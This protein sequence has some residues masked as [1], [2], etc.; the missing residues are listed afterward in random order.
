MAGDREVASP[1]FLRLA[2]HPLRW[3]L[4][5]ELSTGD[6][7]VRELVERTGEPQNLVSYHLRMLR[8]GGLVTARRSSRD[9]RDTYYHLDL[10]HCAAGLADVGAALHPWLRTAA[11]RPDAPGARGRAD[12]A[13]PRVLFVCTG[14]SARSPIAEAL[15]RRRA[16]D[17]VVAASAGVS[18]K[19]RIHP[20]AVRVLRERFDIDIR[21]QAPRSVAAVAAAGAP[22]DRVV[23]LCDKAR[24]RLEAPAA[25]RRVHWSVPDPAD[26]RGPSGYASF[27]S[28]ADDIDARVRHLVP[29]LVEQEA[30]T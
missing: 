18:P 23:T 20:H 16:G 2:D 25:W 24:E 3:R 21:G 7:R 19:D 8:D 11:A 27:I 17:R 29:T 1:P 4:L 14:N 9:G 13:V 22:F 10:D 12:V 15:L 26:A 6:Q 5:A 30:R 28:V